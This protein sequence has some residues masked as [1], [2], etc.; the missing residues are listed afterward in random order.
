MEK[1]K[2][3][4]GWKNFVWMEEGVPTSIKQPNVNEADATET[5]RYTIGGDIINNPQRGINIVKMSDG[6]TRKIIVK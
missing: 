6:T 1:Y 2:S 5:Q 4:N 3:T